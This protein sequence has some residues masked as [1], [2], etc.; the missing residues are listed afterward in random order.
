MSNQERI[1]AVWR[2]LDAKHERYCST[3]FRGSN[4]KNVL[5]IPNDLAKLSDDYRVAIEYHGKL[6]DQ[7]L[8]D[9]LIEFEH[10]KKE[11]YDELDRKHRFNSNDAFASEEVIDFWS[12]AEYWSIGEAA[13]L[14][15]ERNP[16]FVTAELI[17]R[18]K[19]FA[20]IRVKLT[21]MLDLLE[22][23]RSMGSLNHS[24]RPLDVIQWTILKEIPMPK[25]LIEL[26]LA[27]GKTFHNIKA[28]NKKLH[29]RIGELELS[30]S[31]KPVEI[32]KEQS[33]KPIG[34]RE[35]S[36]LLKLFL[37]LA[38]SNYGLDSRTTS[39]IKVSEIKGDLDLKGINFDDG[40]IK[41]YLDEAKEL[42][43]RE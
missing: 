18:D 40:T 29:D 20:S 4:A 16:A 15:N 11:L 39:Q 31:N 9:L 37:G 2:L 30:L 36:T 41:K 8:P 35:R 27:R 43:S 10:Y 42:L 34:A 1:V 14:I 5:Q 38:L 3:F 32:I 21:S 7:S 6:L 23:A 12:R 17:A 24:N 22:R 33:E 13:A 28:E 19:S 26:T 25:R